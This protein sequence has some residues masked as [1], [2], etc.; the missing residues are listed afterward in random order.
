[1]GGGGHPPLP[2]SKALGGGGWHEAMVLVSLPSAAPI[3]LSPLHSPTLC[4]SER[5]LVVPTEPLDDISR[6]QEKE[7]T[8]EQSRN[9]RTIKN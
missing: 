4:G 8:N 1:M 6:T 9:R 7:N 3:G 5:G 2:S